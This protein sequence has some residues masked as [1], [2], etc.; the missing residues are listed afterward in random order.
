LKFSEWSQD[1]IDAGVKHTTARSKP[2]P[3]DPDVLFMFTKPIPLGIIK[4]YFYIEEGASSPE[5]LQKKVN[6]IW[7]REVPEDRELF[8]HVLKPKKKGVKNAE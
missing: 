1:R 8:L 5:E 2:Q 3:D 7:R 4:K 6:Q